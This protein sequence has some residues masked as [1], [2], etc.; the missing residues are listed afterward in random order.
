MHEGKMCFHPSHM[1]LPGI[2]GV[3]CHLVDR[4]DVTG[5]ICK[6]VLL[7]CIGKKMKYKNQSSIG[8]QINTVMN[9]QSCGVCYSAQ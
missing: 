7:L 8:T 9:V 3:I 6:K 1:W 5:F 2:A 4:F